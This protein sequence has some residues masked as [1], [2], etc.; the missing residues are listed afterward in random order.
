MCTVVR[1]AVIHV[2]RIRRLL[3]TSTTRRG[4]PRSDHV[5]RGSDETARQAGLR[6]RTFR[7]KSAVGMS[8]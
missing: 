3:A 4:V 2:G 1:P 7:E 6:S 5:S 8:A